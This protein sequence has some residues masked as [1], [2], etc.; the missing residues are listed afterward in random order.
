[1][2]SEVECEISNRLNLARQFAHEAGQLTL[3]YF[4][5]SDLVVDRKKDMTPITVADREAEQ[6]LREM[7][8]KSFPLDGID[9][10]SVV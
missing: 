1:M 8:T 7:I 5:D 6:L 10:K 9:R 4:C 3:K 2:M